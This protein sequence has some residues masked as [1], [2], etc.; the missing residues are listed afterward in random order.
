MTN[1]A[2]ATVHSEATKTPPPDISQLDRVV[3]LFGYPIAHS[4]SPLF[5]A[6]I[7][8]SLSLNYLQ[9]L[10]ETRTLTDCL[11][12]TKDPKFLG[13]SVTM[14]FKVAI[15]PYL[16]Q[17]TPE[18][19]AIGAINTIYHSTSPS[20]EKILCGTNTD[21][22]GI[23]EAL[24][25]NA[26]PAT[27]SRIKGSA[28]MVIGGGGTCRAAVYALKKFLGCETIY[29]VN[30]DKS[31]CDAVIA[32][33]SSNGFGDGLLYIEWIA[34]AESLPAPTVIVS[35]IPDFAPKSEDEHR[36][37]GI[38]TEFLNREG[39]KGAVLEM[40]YHPSPDT[41]IAALAIEAGWQVVGGVESMVYQGLEQDK[42]WLGVEVEKL[43]VKEVRSVVLQKLE[44]DRAKH[45]R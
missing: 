16:D 42:V 41:Q 18:G 19:S 27:I 43:P 36:A 12:L 24:L 17:L 14:P 2:D 4:L 39:E 40:C 20:G 44:S 31:E 3:Y 33:C 25:H 30:R 5:H 11:E 21:C 1:T 22:I 15:I 29:M 9:H 38:I 7:F 26:S 35:A 37:R 23:R 28:G 6:T 13:A 45:A 8:R 10:Y 32:E 34:Q